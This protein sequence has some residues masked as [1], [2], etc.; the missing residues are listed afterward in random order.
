VL[1][2]LLHLPAR[3]SHTKPLPR[4]DTSAPS[5]ESRLWNAISRSGPRPDAYL[6]HHA[7]SFQVEGGASGELECATRMVS[8]SIMH[9]LH[10]TRA[11]ADPQ[12]EGRCGCQHVTNK[13][14]SGPKWCSA[15]PRFS[16]RER[17]RACGSVPLTCRPRPPGESRHRRVQGAAMSASGYALTH[18]RSA[19]LEAGIANEFVEAALADLRAE[20]ALPAASGSNV[21]RKFLG[22]PPDTLTAR[23]VLEATPR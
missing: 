19:A 17:Q 9:D 15:T 1:V 23:R 16:A 20:R 10:Y 12:V 14:G 21:A 5:R 3:L 7:G 22:H 8:R 6:V 4:P 11:A 18:V 13:K 2:P